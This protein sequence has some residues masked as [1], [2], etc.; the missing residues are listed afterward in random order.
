MLDIGFGH[1][2]MGVAMNVESFEVSTN[3]RFVPSRPF[4]PPTEAFPPVG[5]VLGYAPGEEIYAQEDEKDRLYR[6]ISGAVRTSRLLA[7]GRRQVGDFYYEG[8][9]F[10]VEAGS[11]HR[12]SAEALND[13]QILVVRCSSAARQEDGRL[14]R[15][16]WDAT[17]QE[18]GRT[19]EH[20]SLLARTS[21]CEKVATFLL[22]L[23]GRFRADLVHL[24]MG[25]QDMADY[26][27]ITLETIS[28]TLS[29][30][31][32]D[33]VVEFVGCRDYRVSR[34]GAL[35]RLALS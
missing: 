4:S 3:A 25:R 6:V 34:P 23:A 31:Q 7:D 9:L 12:F 1:P 28:R 17:T 8:D 5:M 32:A 11:A 15:L 24:P 22:N 19:Q 30:L 29:R 27:G 21:A 13:C 33:G 14:E 35:E 2:Q 10:G 20:M 18:L 16:I 26:L